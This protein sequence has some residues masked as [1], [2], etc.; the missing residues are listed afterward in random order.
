MILLQ[1]CDRIRFLQ[2]DLLQ[3]FVEVFLLFC[4]VDRTVSGP[5]ARGPRSTLVLA[6]FDGD[7]VARLENW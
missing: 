7:H 3:N 1:G 2:L 6:T 4:C 5:L